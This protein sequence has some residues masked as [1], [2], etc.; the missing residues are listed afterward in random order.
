MFFSQEWQRKIDDDMSEVWQSMAQPTPPRLA[1][2]E[3]LVWSPDAT[4]VAEG[5]GDSEDCT[6]GRTAAALTMAVTANDVR[7]EG[8]PCRGV[9][10]RHRQP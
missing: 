4:P 5:T 7:Q 3:T 8:L 10:Q 9:A 2:S 6:A 1:R